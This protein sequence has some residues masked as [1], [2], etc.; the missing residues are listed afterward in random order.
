MRL[1][2]RFVLP[3]IIALAAIAWGVTPLVDQM[4]LRWFTRDM[5]IRAELIANA[6]REPLLEN[7]ASGSKAKIASY[8]A[9]IA[10]DE[11]LYAIGY[12]ASPQAQPLATR[13]LPP[14]IR[15]ENLAQW[16]DAENPILNSS[17]GPLHVA[18]KPLDEEE[19]GS[20]WLVLIHDM[21]FVTRRSEETKAY[22]FYFFMGL[23]AVISLITVIIAQLSWRGW[24]TGMR[25][26]LRGEGLVRQPLAGVNAPEFQPIA[27][28]LQQLIQEL[29][30]DHRSRDESQITWTPDSLRAVLHGELRGDDVIVVANREPYIHQRRGDA[31][32]VQR[33]ASGLV[34]A[35]EPIMR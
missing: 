29:E 32:E 19:S 25:S 2:L 7:L 35:L 33:P 20:G 9:R 16:Q 30:S 21:S 4:T 18:V 11:R 3:L 8:F 22:V 5:D 17:R 6:M 24:V 12:C 1:S 14:Q 23:A 31:I 26:L 15:C 13:S 27:R 10:Q 34:T 28:D